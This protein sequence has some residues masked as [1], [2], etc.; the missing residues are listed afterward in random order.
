MAKYLISMLAV[1]SVLLIGVSIDTQSHPVAARG[2]SGEGP[3]M[4]YAP[5]RVEG[6]GEEIELRTLLRGRVESLLVDECSPVASGDVLMAL[7]DR[8]Y[9]HEVALAQAELAMAEAKLQRLIAVAVGGGW[10]ALGYPAGVHRGLQAV[11][12]LHLQ[13]VGGADGGA[14]GALVG[15]QAGVGGVRARGDAERQRGGGEPEEGARRAKHGWTLGEVKEW[16]SDE[17]A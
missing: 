10:G 12:A 3:E 1:G 15:G 17:V 14:L 13:L 16:A 6:A 5:G 8:Q 4:I 7:D 2:P 9:Q 11:R